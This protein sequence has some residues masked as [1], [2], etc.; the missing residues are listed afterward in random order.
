MPQARLPGYFPTPSYF[1]CM[2]SAF[3]EQAESQQ[4]SSTLGLQGRPSPMTP[5]MQQFPQG[6]PPGTPSAR[7]RAQSSAAASMQV[8]VHKLRRRARELWVALHCRGREVGRLQLGLHLCE[9]GKASKWNKTFETLTLMLCTHLP[10]CLFLGTVQ[11]SLG[12]TGI[13]VA[14]LPPTPSLQQ[15]VDKVL[16]CMPRW[17]GWC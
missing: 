17:P 10:A 3:L 12:V 5:A 7:V 15:L 13:S 4:G 6:L 11:A 1:S 14:G 16:L 9:P 8:K 2:L